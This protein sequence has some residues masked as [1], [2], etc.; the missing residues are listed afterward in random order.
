MLDRGTGGPP[1][2]RR[3]AAALA[4]GAC[5]DPVAPPRPI[6]AAALRRARLLRIPVLCDFRALRPA[7]RACRVS[8]DDLRL[9]DGTALAPIFDRVPRRFAAT[10][11]LAVRRRARPRGVQL[12]SSLEHAR[13][14]AAPR[15]LRRRERRLQAAQ[16]RL[17]APRVRRPRTPAA[18]PGCATTPR[19]RR[20][21]LNWAPKWGSDPYTVPMPT[22]E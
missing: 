13:C 10:R 18:N 17:A 14:R 6:H 8:G 19:H 16:R 1:D 15:L 2:A 7:D 11:G 5:R 4:A 20:T 22:K 3:P 21:Q 9:C 12:P